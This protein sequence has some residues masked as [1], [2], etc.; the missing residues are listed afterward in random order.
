MIEG[1]SQI[2]SENQNNKQPL[3][4]PQNNENNL[5]L[6][7]IETKKKEEEILNDNHT[8]QDMII[9]TENKVIIQQVPFYLSLYDNNNNN[10]NNINNINNINNTNNTNNKRYKDV[11]TKRETKFKCPAGFF[12]K[13][14]ILPRT[15]MNNL[16]EKNPPVLEFSIKH[17]CK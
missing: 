17:I 2:P 13:R 4:S 10:N 11:E 5:K 7:L 6:K 16:E 15:K 14:G 1:W 12:S 3:I 9:Q 8:K